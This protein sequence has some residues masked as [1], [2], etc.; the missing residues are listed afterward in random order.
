MFASVYISHLWKKTC[1][2][3]TSMCVCVCTH[4]HTHILSLSHVHTHTH[5]HTHITGNAST[6][7]C[8]QLVRIFFICEKRGGRVFISFRVLMQWSCISV[9]AGNDRVTPVAI[10]V[11]QSSGFGICVSGWGLLQCFIS[12]IH[13]D[14]WQYRMVLIGLLLLHQWLHWVSLC[15]HVLMLL[16][17]CVYCVVCV[18]ASFTCVYIHECMYLWTCVCVYV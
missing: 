17:V 9:S 5:T 13:V 7:S 14:C 16:C 8:I 3:Y 15:V 2:A 10:A 12:A 1:T 6:W 11:N 18:C 4:T